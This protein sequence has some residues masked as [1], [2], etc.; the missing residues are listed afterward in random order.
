MVEE[1]PNKN[2]PSDASAPGETAGGLQR[3]MSSKNFIS[4]D[5][6]KQLLVKY[7]RRQSKGGK[8]FSLL[9]VEV[10]NYE[11]LVAHAGDDDVTHM[12]NGVRAT[13]L[14]NCREADRISLIAPGLFLILLPEADEEGAGYALARIKNALIANA[15]PLAQ[16][17]PFFNFLVASS[18]AGTCDLQTLL[19]AV[20][21]ILD[22]H[23]QLMVRA[24]TRSVRT[25]GSLSSWLDR[26]KLSEK[27]E[28]F[29]MQ[30]I[31]GLQLESQRWS[32][33]DLW[34]NRELYIEKYLIVAMTGETVQNV[35]ND[36]GVLPPYEVLVQR[37]RALQSLNS[38]YIQHIFDFFWSDPAT[39]YLAVEK[40]DGQKLF[41]LID[42]LDQRQLLQLACDFATAL[43]QAQALVPSLR[44]PFDPDAFYLSGELPSLQISCYC[45]GYLFPDAQSQALLLRQP[46]V[47]TSDDHNLKALVAFLRK[48]TE[49]S[50]EPYA[51]SLSRLAKNVESGGNDEN[52]NTLHKVRSAINKLLNEFAERN[53]VQRS[54]SSGGAR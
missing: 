21:C 31:D 29:G 13:I 12:M 44:I 52:L 2:L 27:P 4:P 32:A 49:N 41:S 34:G 6:F 43:I 51:L 14:R 24:G 47:P 20:G 10:A 22:E 5:E 42:K 33:R 48:L 16:I 30:A 36:S 38:P 7:S 3:R 40:L 15:R 37:A 17:K 18:G 19:A 28:Q 39:L 8:P 11:T 35:S 46:R 26:Y 50:T 9:S 23:D 54:A 53:G 1:Y 45:P 25:L